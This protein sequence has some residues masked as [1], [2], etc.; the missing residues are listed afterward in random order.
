MLKAR[1]HNCSLLTQVSELREAWLWTL[2]AR[3]GLFSQRHGPS[4]KQ[5][6]V[7][8]LFISGDVDV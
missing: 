3:R 1:V 4:Q 6:Q 7:C 5:D 2:R 8:S